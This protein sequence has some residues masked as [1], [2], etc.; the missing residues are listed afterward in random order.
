MPIFDDA[1]L[2]AAVEGLQQA[3][4]VQQAPPKDTIRI[5]RWATIGGGH[6]LDA[7]STE[8]ALGRDGTHELNP[9]VGPNMASRLAIKGAGALGSGL[10]LDK[11]AKTHPTLANIIGMGSGGAM[12]LLGLR[13]LKQ[14]R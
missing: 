3:P 14:G 8:I 5:P 6:A 9:I 11:V 4:I 12:A 13:N 7:I 10:L 1:A 2:M